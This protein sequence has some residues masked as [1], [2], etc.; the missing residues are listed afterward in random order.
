MI[1]YESNGKNDSCIR[2]RDLIVVI[3]QMISGLG[4]VRFVFEFKLVIGQMIL[5]LVEKVKVD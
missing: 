5:S 3:G 4:S 2:S 1:R